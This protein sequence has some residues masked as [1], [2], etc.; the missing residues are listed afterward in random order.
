MPD[1]RA[2][3]GAFAD[4]NF[5]MTIPII[6]A[7]RPILASARGKYISACEFIVYAIAI[8]AIMAPQ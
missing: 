6:E 8:D 2:L 7:T 3:A 1:L 4:C 5:T